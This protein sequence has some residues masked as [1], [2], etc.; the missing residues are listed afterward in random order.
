M[1]IRRYLPYLYGVFDA[2]LER[3]ETLE[4]MENL[5]KAVNK[6]YIPK[7]DA[8]KVLRVIRQR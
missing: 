3:R 8:I 1:N 7:R 6:G 5:R 2:V 4:D